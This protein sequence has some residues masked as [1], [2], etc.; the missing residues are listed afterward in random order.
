MANSADSRP[1][2]DEISV[3]GSAS[4]AVKAF[5]NKRINVLLDVSNFLI[6]KQQV[7]LTVRSHRIEK[8]LNDKGQQ[9]TA[10]GLEQFTSPSLRVVSQGARQSDTTGQDLPTRTVDSATTSSSRQQVA[11][12]PLEQSDIRPEVVVLPREVQQAVDADMG[13]VVS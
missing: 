10:A 12:A 7:Q 4:R 8:Y 5:T 1:V 11:V 13:V 9:V 6:W 3:S 2:E